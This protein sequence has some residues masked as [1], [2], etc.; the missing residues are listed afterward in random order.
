[1]P[2][3]ADGWNDA[4]VHITNHGAQHDHPMYDSSKHHLLLEDLDEI[5]QSENSCAFETCIAAYGRLFGDAHQDINITPSYC[6]RRQIESIVRVAFRAAV[7][8][9]IK[10]FM[11]AANSFEVFGFDL[12]VR[13]DDFAVVL[14]EVNSGPRLFG[15]A[16]PNLCARIV[17]DTVQV[18]FDPFLK[19]I[20][21]DAQLPSPSGRYTEV[22]SL[23]KDLSASDRCTVAAD[24]WT[25]KYC[26][27]KNKDTT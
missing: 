2:Y 19:Q 9:G 4:Y 15:A 14:L 10:S 12:M 8:G 1:M 26:L 5:L 24:E 3:S 20:D 25:S 11:P 17:E 18:V 16:D 13:A 6:I 22:L 21:T 7:A 27:K 23:Y